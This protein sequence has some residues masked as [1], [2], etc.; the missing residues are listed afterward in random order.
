VAKTHAD[1]PYH[2]GDART[3][4]VRAAGELLEETGAS[5]L[6]LRGVAERAGLS[7]QAPYNHFAD[8]E[9]L[10]AALAAVGFE[11][12][13]AAVREATAGLGGEAA[14][15]ASGEAYI[16]LAQREP[17]L[18]RLMFGRELVDV[19]KFEDA[20][21]ASCKA[22]AALL[23]VIATLCAPDQVADLGLAAWCLVHGYASLCNEAGIE[24][25]G[26]RRA[27]ARQFAGII[28]ASVSKR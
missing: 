18:F 20:A 11:R 3:A 19:A 25:P 10:L 5:G 13:E 4:L 21:H 24:G 2:H 8:K 9:A 14:L 22:Y 28:A 16:G 12:L 6:S 26:S 7:R 23:E 15:A 27:R 17:H 1:K